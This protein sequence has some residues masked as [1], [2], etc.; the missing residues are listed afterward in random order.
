MVTRDY[1]LIPDDQGRGK[2]FVD[3]CIN[4]RRPRVLKSRLDDKYI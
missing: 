2:E 3:F 4:P 1:S